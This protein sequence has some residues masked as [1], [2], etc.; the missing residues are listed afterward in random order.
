MGTDEPVRMQAVSERVPVEESDAD[1]ARRVAAGPP[2]DGEA[3]RSLHDR[4]ADRLY[5]VAYRIVRDAGEAQDVLQ[6]TWVKLCRHAGRYDPSRPLS[7]WLLR[8]AGNLARNRR[9]WLCV[10]RW[11]ALPSTS[12]EEP[13]DARSP[14][15]DASVSD[16]SG[17][18]REALEHLRARQRDAI[19]LH[20]SEGLSVEEVARSL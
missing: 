4:Y 2:G 11:V 17:R 18:L 19:L 15:A 5:G 20:Y 6:E 8:I 14:F 9:R 16:E 7:A 10:R 1:L 13:A 3:L 12:A